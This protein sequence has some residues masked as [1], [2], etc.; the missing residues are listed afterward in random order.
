MRSYLHI[1]EFSWMFI[2]FKPSW[3]HVFPLFITTFLL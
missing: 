1:L 3:S 2:P